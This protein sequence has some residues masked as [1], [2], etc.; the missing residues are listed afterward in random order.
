[1]KLNGTHQLLVYADDVNL[2]GDNI[3]TI[4][5]N[6]ETLIDASKEVGPEV[7]AEKPKYILLARLQNAGQNYNTE[8]VNRSFENVEKLRYLGET[9]TNKNLINVEIMGRLICGNACYDSVQNLLPLRLLFKN[10]KIKTHKSVNFHIVLYGCETLTLTLRVEHRLWVFEN[11]VLRRIFGPKRD[12]TTVGWRK[13]HNEKLCN[14]YSSPNIIRL[15]K[16]K[17]V[18]WAG[19]VA[20]MRRRGTHIGFWW[21]SQ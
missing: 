19:H 13:L 20:G 11:R 10:V 15:I 9:G 21:E 5:K 8:R 18:Q 12:E 4:K 16:S 6:T 7:N 1:V 3:G 17:R 14:L 2:L